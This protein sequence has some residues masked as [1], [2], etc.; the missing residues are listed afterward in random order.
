M[1]KRLLSIALLLLAGSLP[2]R[3]HIPPDLRGSQIV[4]VRVEG[5]AENLSSLREIGIPSG[6]PLTRPLIRSVISRLLRTGRWSDVQVDAERV[7]RGVRLVMRLTPRFLIER[8]VIEGNSEVSEKQIASAVEM[9]MGSR[10]SHQDL[11][12]LAG[13]VKRVYADRGYLGA[14]VQ[15]GL[16]DT[17]EVS[18]KVVVVGIHEG[19][20]TRVSDISFSGDKP[21][22]PGFA[23]SALGIG[24]GDVLDRRL[25]F[26]GVKR[27]ELQLRKRGY[28]EAE[29]GSP[30][31]SIGRRG[32]SLEIPCSIG[33]RYR[34]D[35]RGFQPLERS[36]VKEAM[37]IEQQALTADGALEAMR[38][39]VLDLYAR[40][41]YPAAEVRID[42][43]PAT[44]PNR[45]TLRVWIEAG[46]Q[47][48]IVAVNFPGARHFDRD[49]LS[50]EL[51]VYL[52][53][54]LPGSTFVYPV[55][56]KVVDDLT[57]GSGRRS[58]REVPAPPET[59]PRRIYYPPTYQEAI[60][61]MEE[62]Y[63]ADGFLSASVGPAQI[64][65]IDRNRAAVAIPVVEGPR[66]L[67]HGVVLKGNRLLGAR[68]LLSAAGLER[69]MPFSYLRMEEA[70]LRLVKLYQEEGYL[71]VEVEPSVRFSPDNTRAEMVIQVD[72]GFPVYV[73]EIVIR[74]ARHTSEHLIRSLSL[75]E[76]G[77][78]YRPSLARE[79]EERL[80]AL[81]VFSG[82][83]VEPEDPELAAPVKRVLIMVT[84]RPLQLLDVSAGVSTG[85]GLR[86]GFEYGYRNLFGQAVSTSLRVQFAYRLFLLTEEEVWRRFKEQLTTFEEQLERR[87]TLTTFIPHIPGLTGV[88]TTIDLIYL[89]NIERD[90]VLDTTAVALTF[91]YPLARRL[92]VSLGSGLENNY[93]KLFD[94]ENVD[95]YL[96]LLADNND[97]DAPRLSR[98]LRVPSGDSTLLSV[99]ASLTYDQRD[100]PFVP[101]RGYLAS[102]RTEW[103]RTLESAEIETEPFV[104]RFIKASFSTSGYL[105]LGRSVVLAGQLRAG[106]IFHLSDAS[107]TYPNRAFYL[108]GV[109][110]IRGYFQDAMMPQDKADEI[111]SQHAEAEATGQQKWNPNA[112]VRSADLF[113]LLRV[114]LRFPLVGQLAAGVFTD[115]GNSWADPY[116]RLGAPRQIEFYHLR[117]SA[118]A[119]IR[120]A[121]PVGPLALDYGILLD[122]R[123]ELDEPFGT[124]HFSIGLF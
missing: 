104:S 31:V 23:I 35:I 103:A 6:A 117:P 101:T 2:A 9:D 12:T 67:L 81:G 90:F 56:D 52:E 61:H 108:G 64:E 10:V 22:D 118:G 83:K 75:L 105:P 18:R 53:E 62:L 45:A 4:E 68:E 84:E 51:F 85:Q 92:M 86:T 38:G 91:G 47:T 114:E 3:A 107:R 100:N 44:R 15:V 111:E 59:D 40:H 110:T 16:R 48:T 97:P 25:L 55:D 124:L 41:G 63:Q 98:L 57:T 50:Q 19:E 78:L 14:E 26:E 99:H 71:F 123:K 33:P 70:R 77:N 122:R 121:T 28:F 82:V 116:G 76:P 87:V 120:L 119:G 46:E 109:D 88:R 27:Y 95:Q 106:S 39:R 80:L 43:A 42:R 17:A 102:L 93:V 11:Y 36:T 89:R 66:T 37:Q 54:D 65:R 74:G 5:G 7:P 49:Y 96:G 113:L 58:R 73:E 1:V 94:A 21:P 69:E 8:V 20:P 13:K 30:L 34:L 115:L 60:R 29:M 112:F 79:T 32:A 72:E 24:V